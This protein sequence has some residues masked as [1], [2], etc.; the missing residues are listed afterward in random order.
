MS[1]ER[2]RITKRLEKNPVIECNKIQRKFYPELFS[3]F[4][5]VTDP[6]NKS[7]IEYSTRVMLGGMIGPIILEAAVMPAAKP[8][9]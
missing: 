9:S 1:R 3:K 6:R 7:Y 2:D 8:G 4:E 5:Q